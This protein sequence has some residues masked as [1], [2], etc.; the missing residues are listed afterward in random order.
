MV[1]VSEPVFP[2]TSFSVFSLFVHTWFTNDFVATLLNLF[3]YS[4][5]LPKLAGLILKPHLQI[6]KKV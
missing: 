2:Q 4:D 5:I 6:H 3:L 1:T